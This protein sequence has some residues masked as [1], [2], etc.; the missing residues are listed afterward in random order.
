MSV[1]RDSPQS[2]TRSWSMPLAESPI[3]PDWSSSS[4]SWSSI[5]WRALLVGALLELARWDQSPH[6]WGPLARPVSPWAPPRMGTRG[7]WSRSL[8]PVRELPVL[9]VSCLIRW[10]WDS[11]QAA[12]RHRIDTHPRSN[13][14]EEETRSPVDWRS[15]SHCWCGTSFSDT[16]GLKLLDC[17]ASTPARPDP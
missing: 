9:T 3:H 8:Q 10:N 4:W 11:W 5:A 6:P 13:S 7:A 1:D 12:R 15:W 17:C 14:K 16:W 2:T